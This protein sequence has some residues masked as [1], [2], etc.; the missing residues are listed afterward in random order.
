MACYFVSGSTDPG[1]RRV[2]GPRAERVSLS[3]VIVQPYGLGS[4]GGWKLVITDMVRTTFEK[5]TLFFCLIILEYTYNFLLSKIQSFF[6]CPEEKFGILSLLVQLCISCALCICSWSNSRSFC[7]PYI[8]NHTD[9][10]TSLGVAD[11]KLT[12]IMMAHMFLGVVASKL[13]TDENVDQNQQR[14]TKIA[15]QIF[16]LLLRVQKAY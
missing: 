16:S 11:T 8:S 4:S 14:W 3:L 13:R 5:I 7:T 12:Y 1:A 9:G 10:T 2:R 15:P 6:E